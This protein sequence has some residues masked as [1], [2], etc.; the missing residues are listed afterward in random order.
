MKHEKERNATEGKEGSKGEDKAAIA[1]N[2]LF[3]RAVV[4]A[5]LDTQGTLCKEIET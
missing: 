1:C 4:R 2:M 5:T 3:R